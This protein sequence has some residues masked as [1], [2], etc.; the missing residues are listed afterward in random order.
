MINFIELIVIQCQ[1]IIIC[2]VFE[3]MNSVSGIRL[4]K[5]EYFMELMT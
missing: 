2:S 3:Y 5:K 4:R 1:E